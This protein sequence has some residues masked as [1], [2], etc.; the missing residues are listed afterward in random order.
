MGDTF[1]DARIKENIHLF[2]R[3]KILRSRMGRA[4]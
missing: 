1:R 4:Q 2:I 3:D